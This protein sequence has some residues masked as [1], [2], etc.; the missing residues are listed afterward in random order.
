MRRIVTALSIATLLSSSAFAAAICKAQTPELLKKATVTCE[1]ARKTAMEKVPDGKI[2]EAE[3][4]DEH[5]RLVYSFDMKRKG[6]TGV[7]EVQVDAKSGEVVSVEH[8]G[9]KAEQQE[10]QQEKAKSGGR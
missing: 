10:K 4:E 9:P 7:E 3:L 1:G 8:E 5:G 6:Q 2:V